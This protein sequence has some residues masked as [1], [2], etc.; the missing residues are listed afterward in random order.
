VENFQKISRLKDRSSIVA[1]A[2]CFL[3]YWYGADVLLSG[4][5]HTG[6]GN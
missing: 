3:L 2:A 5:Q 4:N 1:A 6:P